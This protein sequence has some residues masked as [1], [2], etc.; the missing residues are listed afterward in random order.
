MILLGTLHTG[1]G[2]TTIN[3][4]FATLNIP[5]MAFKTFKKNER[6]VGPVEI[7]AKK[8]CNEAAE[9]ERALV[10]ENKENLEQLL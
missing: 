10:I 1:N 8:S 2:Y 5:N 4:L 3:K 6:E 9:K 7:V